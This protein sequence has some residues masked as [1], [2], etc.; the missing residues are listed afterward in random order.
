MIGARG[1]VASVDGPYAEVRMEAAAGCGRCH[2][3]GG[4]G[5]NNLG[6]MLCRTPRAY[7]VLNPS[8]AQV[9]EHV[10]IVIAGGVLRRTAFLAYGLPLAL[11]FLGAL[12]GNFVGGDLAAGLGALVGVLA[13]W[14]GAREIQRS[15]ALDPGMQPYIV[16]D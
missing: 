5:G 8:S 12:A 13:G 9:G 7:R 1:I 4:C 14:L 2:E 15:R 16:R 6:S 10:S 11:L 3:E